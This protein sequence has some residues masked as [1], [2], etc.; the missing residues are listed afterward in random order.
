MAKENGDTLVSEFT[1]KNVIVTYPGSTTYIVLTKGTPLTW[2][3]P[4]RIMKGYCHGETK[5]QKFL[6]VEDSDGWVHVVSK[7]ITK[8]DNT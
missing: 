3:K 7:K 2:E 6:I 5:V 8:V 1:G 4:E